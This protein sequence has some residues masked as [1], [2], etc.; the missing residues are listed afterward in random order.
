M[1]HRISAGVILEHQSRLLLV[2]HVLPGRYDFWVAPGGGV[3]GEEELSAAAVREVWEESG[4]LV[5]A[6][7][8]AYIEELVEPDLRVC[9]F[10]FLGSLLG[11]Q[12]STAAPAAKAEHITEAAWLTRQELEGRTVFPPV[13]RAEYWIH[14]EER[15]N[16]PRHLALRRMD[17]W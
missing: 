15:Y 5:E 1:K 3:Q 11:G 9:K 17:F 2:R 10:W 13:I 14:R 4:L 6:G 8:L 7:R 12:L 16:S